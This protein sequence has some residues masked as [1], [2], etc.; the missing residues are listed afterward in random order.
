MFKKYWVVT[1]CGSC[2][3]CGDSVGSARGHTEIDISG[4]VVAPGF[5]DVH[6]HNDAALIARSQMSPKLTQGVTIVIAGNCGISGAPYRGAGDPP[7]LPRLVFKSERLMARSLEGILQ[8]AEEAQPAV[9]SA[10]LTGHGF[11]QVGA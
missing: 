10:F 2:K 9:N 3:P 5:I 7:G 11:R 6:T 1:G 8:K 4:L